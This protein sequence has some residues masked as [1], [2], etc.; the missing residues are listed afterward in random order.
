MTA[1]VPVATGVRPDR[2]PRP[3]LLT[4]SAPTAEAERELRERLPG[5]I[6]AA[7]DSALVA[8]ADR[9]AA[10]ADPDHPVRGA[11]VTDG[12]PADLALLHRPAFAGVRRTDERAAR[13]VALLLPGHGSQYPRM[14]VQLY[15][16]F[17][18]V[19]EAMDGFL[20]AYGPG[21]AEL[22]ADWLTARPRIPVHAAERGQP[23]L[24]ALD[25]AIA[26]HLA[27]AGVEPAAL[28]GHSV[29]EFAAFAVAGVIGVA[30]A[31][32]H[33]AAR[34]PHY[35]SA[36]PGG[37]L[38]VAADPD[39]VAG[40][41]PPGAT[42]GVRNGPRQTLVVG[43][44]AA[45][46]VAEQRL[47]DAGRAPVRAQ[48]PVPFHSPLMAPTARRYREALAATTLAPPRIPIYSTRT[49]RRLTD[50]QAVDPEFLAGQV[51]TPVLFW[52]ALDA[53]LTERDVLLVEAGPGRALTMAARAHPAVLEGRSDAVAAMP[54]RAGRPGVE[55]R[56][57]LG[58]LG[59]IWLEG[60]PR[61]LAIM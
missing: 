46:A 36:P 9:L 10:E 26:G 35:S 24:F 51:A 18:D 47:I 19:A 11:F 54:V 2:L 55:H 16:A 17:G 59:R 8:L 39:W 33:L 12:D 3:V 40:L 60:H 22:H 20:R 21:G 42:V 41:L 7:G 1:A 34:A 44:D 50:R 48:I 58:A 38:A 23:L 15:A 56:A 43:T 13:P 32:R 37:L 28:I 53:L 57:L 27:A 4:W 31:A 5:R 14:G 61:P 49:G 29:G 25:V 45:L 30:E 52:D 6:A